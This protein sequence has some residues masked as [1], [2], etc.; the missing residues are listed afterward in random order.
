M[1]SQSVFK[2]QKFLIWTSEYWF[3]SFKDS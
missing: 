1:Y 2:S 3:S